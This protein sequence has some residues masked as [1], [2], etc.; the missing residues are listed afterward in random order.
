MQIEIE[1]MKIVQSAM[2]GWYDVSVKGIKYDGNVS[3]NF[4]V[5]YSGLRMAAI[6][7]LLEQ[8]ENGMLNPG[9][10]WFQEQRQGATR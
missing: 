8:I 7:V 1:K 3:W 9:W 6:G 4:S 2:G 10:A 5:S